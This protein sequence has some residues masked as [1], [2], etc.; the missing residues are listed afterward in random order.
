MMMDINIKNINDLI[1]RNYSKNG[2]YSKNNGKNN[3]FI[4]IDHE[5]DGDIAE[6]E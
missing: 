6:E 3:H 5:V 1:E 2:K 4:E